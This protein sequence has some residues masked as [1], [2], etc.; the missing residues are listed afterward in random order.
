MWM[1]KLMLGYLGPKTVLDGF[2][3]LWYM[4]KGCIG[5]WYEREK[6]HPTSSLYVVL[7]HAWNKQNASIAA[8][9]ASLKMQTWIEPLYWKYICKMFDDDQEELLHPNEF[10]KRFRGKKTCT[11][12]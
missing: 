8:I 12:H 2:Y 5:A 9:K 10:Y 6:W 7:V 4:I 1:R 11:K 3:K